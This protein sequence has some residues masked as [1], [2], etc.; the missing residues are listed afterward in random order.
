M[1]RK[2][3]IFIDGSWLY[4]ACARD[5]ALSNRLEYADKTF[6]LD[7]EK[8]SNALLKYAYDHDS[9]CTE[10]G[11]RI[12]STSIFSLPDDLDDWSVEHDDIT[13][14]DIERVRSTVNIREQFAKSAIDAGYSDEALF[15][16]PLKG[17]MLQ[18]LR[19]NKFQE[20]QVDATVVALLVRSAI[21]N[22]NDYHAIIT[23]DADILPAIKVAYPKYSSN[24]FI[25][26]THPDQ[27]HA[28]SRQTSYSLTEFDYAMDPYYLE[29]HAD[30]LLAGEN[31]YTCVH[32]NKVFSRPNAIPVKARPCC[33]PCHQK[34]T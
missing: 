26:T 16:P 29:Q 10:F 28:E 18:N 4:K 31:V 7:F 5:R 20:K 27:L 34:R 25:A 2:L 3:N 6:K 14:H 13:S 15:R 23:G 21:I 1:T 8:L 32:C 33:H 30:K 19:E 9:D 22:G 12:F 17:W 11:D 24:V